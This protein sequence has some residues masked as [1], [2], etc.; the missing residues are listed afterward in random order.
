MV[1]YSIIFEN[2]AEDRPI[3]K[4]MCAPGESSRT[5]EP[6]WMI[7]KYTYDGA[8]VESILWAVGSND[9]NQIWD[10]RATLTYA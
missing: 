9:F 10:D 3:Y 7:A 5:D 4:G 6:I 8:G 1:T 2:D